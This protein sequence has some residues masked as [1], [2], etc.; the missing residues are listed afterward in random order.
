[1]LSSSIL[2][3]FAQPRSLL[4]ENEQ[5][6]LWSKTYLQVGEP[7]GNHIDM[8]LRMLTTLKVKAGS[9][10]NFTPLLQTCSVKIIRT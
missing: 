5:H 8:V 10:L 2:F 7:I 3:L 1:M 9:I 4:L 6:S